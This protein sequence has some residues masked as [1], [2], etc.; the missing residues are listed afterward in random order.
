MIGIYK[1]TNKVNG[2]MYI[3]GSTNLKHRKRDHFKP[4]RINKFKHLPIYEAMIEFGRENFKFEVIEECS[5]EDLEEREN[6]Y[7][8]KYKSYENGYNVSSH[9]ISMK[10]EEISNNYAEMTRKRNF[11]N[12]AD[13]EYREQMSKANSE[14]QKERLKDP[15]YLAEKSAQ[16]KQY[17]DSIKRPVGQYDKQGNLIAK[18]EGVREAERALDLPNDSV[19]KVCRGVKYRKTAGG[20]VWKY[21]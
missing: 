5:A 17:T 15:E 9:A 21:L 10:D 1:I 13:E 3:G 7:L 8:E 16:L 19:G 4:Y 12:W 11:K 14:F 6:Y 2:K 18:F 20:Y